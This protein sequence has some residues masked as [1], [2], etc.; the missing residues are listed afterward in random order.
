VPV[1]KEIFDRV[2]GDRPNQKE[3]MRNEV[4]VTAADLL[5]FRVEG[6]QVTEDGV[7]SNINIA[8]Q[9]LDAW[10]QGTG[11]AAIYNLMEDTA[12]AE[13]SRTQLW[14][15]VHGGAKLA[16]G[17]MVTTDLYREFRAQE[18]QRLGGQDQGRLRDAG[19]L[20]DRLV[21]SDR[22]VPF[23]TLEAYP[24]LDTADVVR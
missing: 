5:D 14:Q 13:I 16:D 21:L 10:L 23:L 6:G 20:L 11:A 1:A 22:M 3:R 4:K 9:Y 7:R 12:T 24:L 17:R 18:M 15:W 2:L 8:L 19:D